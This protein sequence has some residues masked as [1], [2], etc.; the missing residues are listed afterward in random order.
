M[1]QGTP[2]SALFDYLVLVEKR[3]GMHIGSSR[4]YD[5]FLH[6]GGWWAHRRIFEDNDEFAEHFFENFHGFVGGHYKDRRS[7]GW[8]G[9][10]QENSASEEEEFPIFMGFVRQF[11]AEFSANSR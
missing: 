9:L 4:V 2:S 10:I 1:S 8:A 11:A 7:I 6:L 3:P 5:L